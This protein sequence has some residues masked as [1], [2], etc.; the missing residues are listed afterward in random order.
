MSRLVVLRPTCAAHHLH[1]VHGGEL[2]PRALLR[3]VDLRALDDHC[4]CRQVD[5]PR[6]RGRRHKNLNV[7]I[8]VQIFNKLPVRTRQ[9]SVVDGKTVRQEILHLR[10]LDRLDLCLQNLTRG[11]VFMQ[12][13]GKSVVLHGKIA[14]GLRRLDRL[15]TRVH[16][17]E[18]L[19]LTSV[20][21][22]LLVADLV[23]GVEALDRLLVCDT[24]VR[25][26]ERHRAE[27]VT[28][29]VQALLRVDAQEDGHIL[30]V[31]QRR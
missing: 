23:H 24:N 17:D 22:E 20:L 5:T 16:K 26:L 6:Q 18:D 19:V 11:G 13:L 14:Q 4:V 31:G 9:A 2:V 15:L 1:H 29:V 3:I 25:L 28:E 12:E 30:V 27:L 10:R 8:S 21:H 7:P